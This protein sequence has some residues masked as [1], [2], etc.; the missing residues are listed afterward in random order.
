[1]R[2]GKPTNISNPLRYAQQEPV[3]PTGRMASLQPALHNAPPSAHL[4]RHACRQYRFPLPTG[5]PADDFPRFSPR[6]T[7]TLRWPQAAASGS[8]MRSNTSALN[9]SVLAHRCGRGLVGMEADAGGG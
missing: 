9:A 7:L 2:T 8:A 5:L 1:M 3:V 4:G 6:G